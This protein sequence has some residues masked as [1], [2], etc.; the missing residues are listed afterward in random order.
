M[1]DIITDRELASRIY[2]LDT[3]VYQ[4]TGSSLGKTL[5]A[6]KEASINQLIHLMKT[7]KDKI[8]KQEM[9]LI[10]NMLKTIECSH[11]Y[12]ALAKEYFE[13]EEALKNFDPKIYYLTSALGRIEETARPFP[14]DKKLIICISRQYGCRGQETGIY[15]ARK[16]GLPYYDKDILNKA[17]KSLGFID[18]TIAD[19]YDRPDTKDNSVRMPLFT[20]LGSP[21]FDKLYFAQRKVIQKMAEESSCIFLGR[22]ADQLLEQLMI[23][24]ISIFLCA[25]LEERIKVEMERSNV[26]SVQARKNIAGIDRYRSAFYKFYTGKTWGASEQYDACLN[27]A[28]YGVEGSVELI[29]HMI[30]MRL[31]DTSVNNPGSDK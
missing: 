20:K 2:D 23:P 13:L 6:E 9:I 25:P 8:L 4:A 29:L 18:D 3:K 26:D 11:S 15:L 7:D 31:K 21:S 10:S 12:K 27:T 5:P 28:F 16:T 24:H 30:H 22:C 1:S 14:K 19:P 17:S